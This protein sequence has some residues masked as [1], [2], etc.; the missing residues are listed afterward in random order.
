MK[1]ILFITSLFLI[2]STSFACTCINLTLEDMVISADSIFLA[3]LT[4]TN[5][6]NQVLIEGSEDSA[7]YFP[8][9]RNGAGDIEANFELIDLYKGNSISIQ[10]SVLTGTGDFDCSVPLSIGLIYV[11]FKKDD[12]EYISICNGTRVRDLSEEDYFINLQAIIKINDV[13]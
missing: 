1:N 6:P 3:K 13:N 4:S 11:I 9:G 10:I 2:S 7:L 8:F 5:N 12:S